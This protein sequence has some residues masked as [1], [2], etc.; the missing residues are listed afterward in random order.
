MISLVVS[1]KKGLLGA[2]SCF[3]VQV[4][5]FRGFYNVEKNNLR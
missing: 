2:Y 1:V 3:T 4:S 5:I